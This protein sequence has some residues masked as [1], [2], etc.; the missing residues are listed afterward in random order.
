ML[1]AMMIYCLHAAD[2]KENNGFMKEKEIH[3]LQKY[4]SEGT[5]AEFSGDKSWSCGWLGNC[6]RL[7]RTRYG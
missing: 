7:G 1:L 4:Y 5:E 6:T 3:M 2:E